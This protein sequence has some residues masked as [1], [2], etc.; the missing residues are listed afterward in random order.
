MRQVTLDIPDGKFEFF[1][2]LC[3]NL[4]LSPN[5]EF[6]LTE[7]H[8]QILNERRSNRMSG[9]STIHSWEDVKTFAK[10]QHSK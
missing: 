2:E 9:K 6:T 3:K 5:E 4:G 1:M 10:E 8:L 7:E